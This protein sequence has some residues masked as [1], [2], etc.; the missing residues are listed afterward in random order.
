MHKTTI[1]IIEES[2]E[3]PHYYLEGNFWNDATF[4]KEGRLSRIQNISY[5]TRIRQM[6]RADYGKK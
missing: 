2:T 5:H 3:I 4:T 6:V 1:Q